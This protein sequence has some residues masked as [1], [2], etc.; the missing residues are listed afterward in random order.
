M[1]LVMALLATLAGGCQLVFDLTEPE[2]VIPASCK[3]EGLLL[4]LSFDQPLE[5]SDTPELSVDD[6]ANGLDASVIN[7]ASI[8]REH[9]AGNEL[10]LDLTADSV[11]FVPEN[12]PFDLEGPFSIDLWVRY[13][14]IQV[15]AR[16]LVDNNFQYTLLIQDGRP[17]LLC[18][19]LVTTETGIEQTFTAANLFTEEWHHVACS[20]DGLTPKSY[21]DG[22]ESTFVGPTFVGTIEPEPTPLTIGKAGNL[23]NPLPFVGQ[24]DN[25]RIWTRVLDP[26]E[27]SGFVRGVEG[28]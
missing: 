17:D 11:V 12:S 23:D 8:T 9:V 15:G 1:R 22:T 10:A 16:T 13:R 6:S 14:A 21:V 19:F 26:E 24:L 27:I 3:H 18:N 7:A 25:V 2:P 20:F 5:A 4:C 28:E